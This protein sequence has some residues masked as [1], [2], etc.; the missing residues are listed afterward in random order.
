MSVWGW[1]ALGAVALLVAFLDRVAVG[2]ANPP[3]KPVETTPKVLGAPFEEVALQ[4]DRFTLRGWVVGVAE[5]SQKSGPVLLVLH[6]WAANSGTMIEPLRPAVEAGYPVV[7]M[8]FRG[9]GRSDEAPWVTVR[10]YWEDLEGIVAFVRKR[11][12]G[13]P[14]VVVGHSMG[15][16]I[17]IIGAADGIPLDGIV[18]VASPADILESTRIYLDQ[19]GLPGRLVLPLA[20]PFL[21][22][23]ARVSFRRFVPERRVRELEIPVAMIHG[24]E[25]R[26]VPADHPGRMEQAGKRVEVVRVAGA[27]HRAILEHAETGRVVAEILADWEA[28]LL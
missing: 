10:H 19:K 6:G 3:R 9:H 5:A 17:A 20:L 11:F 14:V 28:E 21:W 12:P 8:D 4:V 23:R 25:D 22:F 2:I 18:C 13:R 27:G 7:F 15:G 16:A 26:R 24:E 1:V